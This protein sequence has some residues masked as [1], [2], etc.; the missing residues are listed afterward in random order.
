MDY[1]KMRRRLRWT[2]KAVFSVE[3][4]ANALQERST[5]SLHVGGIVNKPERSLI[6]Y[7]KISFGIIIRSD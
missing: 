6:R 4:L 5:G 3:S 1:A 2:K 7:Q